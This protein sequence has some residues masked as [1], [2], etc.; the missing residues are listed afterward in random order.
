MK[1]LG[2][3]PARGGSKGIK[4]KNIRNFA[5]KPLI[6]HSIKILKEIKSIDKIIVSTDSKKIA[7][8]AKNYGAEIPFLRPKKISQ[9]NTPML[10][11]LKH[12]VN[13]LKKSENYV[14]D[15][16]LLLQPTSPIRN[17]KMILQAINLLKNS[18]ATSVISVA[19]VKTYPYL[20]FSNKGKFLK[21]L[22]P[23][24]EKN[25]L[26]QKQK[27]V[28]FPTGSFYIFK[29]SNLSNYNSLY[30]PRI[31]PFIIKEKQLNVDI[32]VPF[33]WFVAEMITKNWKNFESKL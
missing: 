15:A 14:P 7:Q 30:G 27:P 19:E 12:C 33:D 13:Y 31:L 23:K 18:N 1:I 8:I 11:V 24:F 32:D 17:S 2:L 28:Y 25:T 21:P 16:I 22:Y 20:S 4:N 29:T 3:V 6:N 5:G 9:D 26:R 10:D